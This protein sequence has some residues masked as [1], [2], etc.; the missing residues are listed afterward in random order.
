M[1]YDHTRRHSN[2][3]SLLFLVFFLVCGTACVLRLAPSTPVGRSGLAQY[4]DLL[5][6]ACDLFDASSLSQKSLI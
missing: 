5:L 1:A 2:Y 6:L 3:E 4:G